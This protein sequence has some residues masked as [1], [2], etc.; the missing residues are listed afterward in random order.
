MLSNDGEIMR[1]LSSWILCRMGS[2]LWVRKKGIYWDQVWW[3]GRSLT[4]STYT[5]DDS[6]EIWSHF[7][8]FFSTSYI[9]I[10]MMKWC[11]HRDNETLFLEKEPLD[12]VFLNTFQEAH[13]PL[14][15]KKHW[16]DMEL[17]SSYVRHAVRVT[18]QPTLNSTWAS[19]RATT[20]A[21][22]A[23][24][25]LTL[26]RISPSCLECRTTLINPGRWLLVSD[27]KSWSFSF[28][29]SAENRQNSHSV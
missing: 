11:S 12:D 5:G 2:A 7:K 10:C 25:P 23:L 22:A 26:D 6:V 24:H 27:T 20:G 8:T 28:S 18:H 16:S 1:V 3:S 9:S 19:K 29:S 14:W 13:T 17:C 15:L 21:V 4:I